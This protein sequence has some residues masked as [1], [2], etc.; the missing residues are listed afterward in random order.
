MKHL[1]SD[2]NAIQPWPVRRPHTAKLRGETTT[3]I[4]GWMGED[5]AA[6]L[7]SL[8]PLIPDDEPVFLI[9]GQDPVG[10][11]A[12]RAY[13]DYAERCGADAEM[14][15]Q[16]YAWAD[17]MEAYAEDKQHGAPDVP[18]GMLRNAEDA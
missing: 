13:A 18:A 11:M 7:N 17:R 5:P 12:V 4:P 15:R 10:G 3:D 16:I 6:R 1:R 9:R 14:V 2:Y 8:T